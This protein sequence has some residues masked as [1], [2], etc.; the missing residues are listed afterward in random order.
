MERAHNEVTSYEISEVI[1]LPFVNL[2]LS[3]PSTIYTC[4]LYAAEQCK[5]Q[6]HVMVTFDQPL[7]TK[8][9]EMALAA[10]AENPLSRVVVQLGG[11]HLLLSFM[12]AVGYI[13]AGSG[14]EDLWET[15]YAKNSVPQ[16]MSG[17]AYARAVRAHMLTHQ[18][19]GTVLLECSSIDAALQEEIS[20]CYVSLF[21]KTATL[22]DIESSDSLN[23]LTTLLEKKMEE[24]AATGRTAKLWV[25]YM[26]S[27]SIIKLFVL[28]ERS[29]D[30]KLH[31]YC[32]QRMLPFFHASGH[33]NY[34]R[35]AHVYLQEMLKLDKEMNPEDMDKFV[36]KGFFTVRRSN[37]FWSGIWT[38]L[39]IEQVLMRDIKTTGGLTEGRGISASTIAKWVHS[40]P[41]TSRIVGAV[42]AFSGVKGVTSEQH[43]ELRE[44]R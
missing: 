39:T 44:S 8:A 35:S 4:L 14:L 17:K 19:V 38:D 32:V 2:D 7:F 34:A 18:A 31:L 9:T 20:S 10:A 3:N 5:N 21:D 22:Q 27:V 42:E 16:M 24:A 41:A 12:G 25:Q 15:I 28:A 13:M 1:P 23:E 37:K 43:V 11:F 36:N 30:W 26:H 29:G 40:M 33:L 6:S